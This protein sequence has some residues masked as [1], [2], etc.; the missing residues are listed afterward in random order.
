MAVQWLYRRCGRVHGPLSLDDL[1]AAVFLGFLGPR[2]LVRDAATEQ[3]VEARSVAGLEPEFG[4]GSTD[5]VGDP[6][7]KRALD[8]CSTEE[9]PS[10]DRS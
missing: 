4:C 8:S 3:W 9:A 5:G 2:D 10:P 7:D 1:K 6:A